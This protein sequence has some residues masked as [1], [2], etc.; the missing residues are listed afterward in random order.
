M[1]W[2]AKKRATMLVG[3]R[4]DYNHNLKYKNAP[5]DIEMDSTPSADLMPVVSCS[6]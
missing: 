3:K 1:I 2:E 6:R 5:H 4:C